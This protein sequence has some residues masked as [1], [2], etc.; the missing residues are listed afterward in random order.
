MAKPIPLHVVVPVLDEPGHTI[1]LLASL[2]AQTRRPT[3]VWVQDNGSST[4]SLRAVEKATPP[5]LVVHVERGPGLT[6][7]ELW[8]RGFWHAKQAAA[9]GGFDVLVTNND[10][11][12]PPHAAE[13]L[14][15]ALLDDPK[16]MAAY[17]DWEAPWS[18]EAQP[19][20]PHASVAITRGV[21]GS[22]GMTGFCFMLAGHRIPWRPLVQDLA[23]HWWFGDNHLARTLELAGGIQAKVLGL[24]IIHAHEGTA[25]SF[26]LGQE[27]EDD[28]KHWE[29]VM[30]ST[31]AQ[32]PPQRGHRV[33]ERGTRRDWRQRPPA[34]PGPGA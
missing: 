6:I 7:Y 12:L 33:V 11:L 19:V 34:R 31:L 24:P 8:N 3:T 32:H 1:A 23:Y 20:E 2:A 15:Q 13:A 16:R 27:K 29:V 9:G 26:D 25:G 17:P 21:W 22:N 10:V 14:G 18:N 4:A 30:R 5:E 28:R